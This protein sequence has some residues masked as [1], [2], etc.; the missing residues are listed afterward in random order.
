MLNCYYMH[1][2][3][4]PEGYGGYAKEIH[5]PGCMAPGIYTIQYVQNRSRVGS[6]YFHKNVDELPQQQIYLC[7]TFS[8]KII[9]KTQQNAKRIFSFELIT[10]TAPVYTL[11]H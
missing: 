4:W 6:E 1:Q 11:T 5:Y 8:R 7:V 10:N 3:L 9:K 2:Y